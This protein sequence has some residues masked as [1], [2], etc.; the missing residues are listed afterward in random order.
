[1]IVGIKHSII[2]I[3]PHIIANIIHTMHLLPIHR[4]ELLCSGRNR[5]ENYFFCSL[6]KG[7]IGYNG[8]KAILVTN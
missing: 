2:N 1:M 6:Y 7:Y 8:K 5:V 3:Y 4:P